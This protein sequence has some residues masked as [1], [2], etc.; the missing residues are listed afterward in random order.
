MATA[1]VGD[2][3]QGGRAFSAQEIGEIRAMVAWLPGL[4]R[5]E[6]AATVCEHL[7]WGF[8]P[9]LMETFVDPRHYAGTCYRAAGWELLGQTSG[10]GLAR[11]GKSYRSTTRLVLAKPLDADF[12]QQ[13][14]SASLSG[15]EVR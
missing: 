11:P 1:E 6:L 2:W 5:R 14:C 4:S 10:R 15:R 3:V 8:T 7:H 12:R 13:L 9:L